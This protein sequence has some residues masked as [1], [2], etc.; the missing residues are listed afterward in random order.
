VHNV[1]NVTLPKVQ[2]TLKRYLDL[3]KVVM[4]ELL[5]GKLHADIN[6]ET[7][8]NSSLV[9]AACGDKSRPE[10]IKFPLQKKSAED[11]PVEKTVLTN[12]MTIL[13]KP[14][15]TSR[16]VA[17]KIFIKGGQGVETIPGESALLSS[18]LMQG[19]QSRTA[20]EISQEL[21]SRG[22]N[23]SVSSGDDAIE[24]TGT[25]ISGD[26][27]DLLLML[28]D[29]MTHPKFDPSEIEKKK[30]I[31]HQSIQAS[32]DTP[33]SV[34]FENLDLLMYPTH[35]YGDIGKRVEANLDKITRD[36]ILDY[37]HRY[38]QPANMVV[39]VVGN[40]DP[41]TLK[42]NLAAFYPDQTALPMT[43]EAAPVPPLV[44]D[45]TVEQSKPRLS[46]IWMAEGWLAPP[47]HVTKTYAALKVMDAMLGS[48]MSSRLFVDLREKQGLAYVVG[49]LYP[50]RKQDS[51]FVIYIGTDPANISKVTTGFADEIKRLKNEPVSSKELEAAK[52]KLIGSF[53]LQHNTNL[54]QAYYLGLYETLGAGYAF[55]KQYPELIKQVTAADIQQAAQTVLNQPHIISI[56][57]PE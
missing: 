36:N 31:L 39:S 8:A 45:E 12:G 3:N 33:S 20:T 52:S 54:N 30:E 19:T 29:I 5:P 46:A 41:I 51:R 22:M 24:I 44:R 21:E 40:F 23:L 56:I 50:S 48:G 13:T 4:V 6:S 9:E 28:S 27:S 57:K 10:E 17:L 35:P 26:L 14:L 32:R 15:K 47:I 1:E 43:T 16:T 49:S 37:Y 53:A 25:A 34:A 2:A 18:V 7:K 38:F 55:D 42:H 11:I